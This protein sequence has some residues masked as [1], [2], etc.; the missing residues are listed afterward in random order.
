MVKI[1]PRDKRAFG[2]T[3]ELL[4]LGY[5]QREGLRLV[6]RNYQCRLGEIDL[7]LQD[8]DQLV[9][10]EVRFR[11]NH[12]HGSALET[13][14]HRKQRKLLLCAQHYLMRRRVDARVNCRFDV[15][16]IT[17]DSQGQHEFTWI[18]NAF[19]L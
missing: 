4:A 14:D 10:L 16:G 12:D 8:G 13:V 1:L 15:L 5:L 2:A 11:K 9:F 6:E 19:Q 18:T 3:Q 7:I 17:C